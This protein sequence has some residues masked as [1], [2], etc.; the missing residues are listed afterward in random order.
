MKGCWVWTLKPC[1]GPAD[2]PSPLISEAL[3]P[4]PGFSASTPSAPGPAFL[5]SGSC[6]PFTETQALASGSFPTPSFCLIR[7]EG[8]ASSAEA[9]LGS[10]QAVNSVSG[11]G[12][13]AE[14][15]SSG[16][17]QPQRSWAL[18]IRGKWV[19]LAVTLGRREAGSQDTGL[20]DPAPPQ[21]L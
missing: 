11:D 3:W 19:G 16:L 17:V 7:P 10:M 4:A 12:L 21:S 20:G 1:P 8:P 15:G 2:L 18:A 5:P 14:Q 9:A 6:P 13:G